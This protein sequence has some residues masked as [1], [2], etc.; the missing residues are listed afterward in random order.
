MNFLVLITR[1][2]DLAILQLQT[3][4]LNVLYLI[5]YSNNMSLEIPT[6][7]ANKHIVLNEKIKLTLFQIRYFTSIQNELKPRKSYK[8]TM[9]KFKQTLYLIKKTIVLI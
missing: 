1:V 9:L 5:H 6:C 3:F 4:V 7:L 2:I 8:L